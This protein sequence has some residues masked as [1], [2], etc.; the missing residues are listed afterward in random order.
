MIQTRFV[1]RNLLL[2]IFVL[3]L[4]ILSR[5]TGK[6]D[7][8]LLNANL[9]MTNIIVVSAVCSTISGIVALKATVEEGK[10]KRHPAQ[11]Y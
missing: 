4:I 8:L 1:D 7:L 3:L 6:L 11:F 2:F 10:G 5:N 9:M